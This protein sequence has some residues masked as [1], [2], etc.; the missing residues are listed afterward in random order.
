MWVVET[1]HYGRIQSLQPMLSD[2]DLMGRESRGVVVSN[3]ISWSEVN[4]IV[5]FEV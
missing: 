3:G 4:E 1:G 2:L 5:V